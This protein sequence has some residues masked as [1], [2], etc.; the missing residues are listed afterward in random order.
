MKSKVI[1]C[2]G[3]PRGDWTCR[4]VWEE[5]PVRIKGAEKSHEE[6]IRKN[7]VGRSSDYRAVARKFWPDQ[8]GIFKPIHPPEAACIFQEWACHSFLPHSVFDREQPT[9]SV[10]SVQMRRI[11]S[12]QSIGGEWSVSLPRAGK[13]HSCHTY[14]ISF[15]PHSIPL[16][17]HDA[18]FTDETPRTTE[19]K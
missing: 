10:P 12:E 15:N 11:S 3:P 9:R 6:Q 18:H 7:Q 19:V 1:T 16:R 8:G 5:K 2:S 14:S 13:L 4:D 17:G